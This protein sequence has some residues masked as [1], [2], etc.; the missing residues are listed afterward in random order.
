GGRAGRRVGPVPGRVA[1]GYDL[2]GPAASLLALQLERD[3]VGAGLDLLAQ[4]G[5][6]VVAVGEQLIGDL[7]LFIDPVEILLLLLAHDLPAVHLD[8]VLARRQLH[9]ERAVRDDRPFPD[10][11]ALGLHERD[12]PVRHGV[13]VERDRA[14]DRPLAAPAARQPGEEEQSGGENDDAAH[15]ETSLSMIGWRG[16]HAGAP[17]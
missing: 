11:A 17:W 15:R 6:L 10:Q 13:A 8:L 4:L 14:A 3:R 12:G 5:G 2:K 7:D 16:P 9:L 1:T